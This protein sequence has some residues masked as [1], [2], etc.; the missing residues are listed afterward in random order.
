MSTL[1]NLTNKLDS[2]TVATLSDVSDVVTQLNTPYIIVGATARDLILHHGYGAAVQRATSDIDFAIQ[3]DSWVSFEAVKRALCA[4][5]FAETRTQHR[6]EN[7]SGRPIDIVPF[8]AHVQNNATIAWP[9]NG[10]VVMN[11]MGF[12]EACDHA[13]SV[14]I[15]EAP[16]LACPVVTPEGFT[17]LKLIAWLDRSEPI[18]HKDATDIGYLFSVFQRLNAFIEELYS[19]TNVTDLERYG[20]DTDLAT[21]FLLGKNCRKIASDQTT[22]EILTLRR[23]TGNRS[24]SRLAVEIDP[25]NAD[26]NLKCL[27]AFMDGLTF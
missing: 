25:R 7:T 10:D 12:Q 4:K 16:Y 24:I 26:D 1:L 3:V 22:A 9:P 5:S 21:C 11:V 8:G 27:E 20:W 17:I 13:Q 18:Q 19:E 15:R 6:L 2:E 23:N 14:I